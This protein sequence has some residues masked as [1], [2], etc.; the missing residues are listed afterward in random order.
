MKL[1]VPYVGTLQPVDIRLTRLAEFLGVRCELLAIPKGLSDYHEFLSAHALAEPACCIVNPRVIRDCI[2]TDETPANLIRCLLSCFTSLL[3][4]GVQPGS[5]DDSIVSALSRGS[6]GSVQE[7]SQSGGTYEIP[8]D[9]RDVCGFFSGLIL[10]SGDGRNDRVFSLSS[11]GQ[12]RTLISRN[13]ESLMVEIRNQNCNVLLIGSGEVADLT[14]ETGETPVT[15]FFSRLLP[16]AIAVRHIFK[17]ECWLPAEPNASVIIDDPLLRPSY[18]FLKFDHLLALTK[19]Y[20]FH[21]TVAFIPHNFRRTSPRIATMFRENADRLSLCFHGNDHTGGEF[22]STDRVWL[23]TIS[24]IAETRML[25]HYE[26]TGLPCDRVMVFPQGKFS[27]E[28]MLALKL[29]NFDCAVN[30]VPHPEQQPV[31]LTL[32]ELMQ[33]AVL[34]YGFPLFLRRYS[35]LVHNADMCFDLFFGRPIVIVEHHDIFRNPAPLISAVSRI[36]ESFPQIRWSSVGKAVK[37]SLLKLRQGDGTLRVRAYSREVEVS[38]TSDHIQPLSVEWDN[39]GSPVRPAQILSN[40]I[41]SSG[42]E[43]TNPEHVLLSA[44]LSPQTSVTYSLVYQNDGCKTFR[45]VSLRRRT[46]SLM[47]RRLSEVR[48]N[49]LEKNSS[50]LAAAKAMQRSLS[51]VRS[52][53][54][55]RDTRKV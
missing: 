19:Q 2:G 34:R 42:A 25:K 47:R 55:N 43:L 31:K 45:K 17:D 3:V 33:P 36:N 38:N 5:F 15:Q 9:S 18:G 30:T 21:V 12:G 48:D 40:G 39:P 4:H 52:G 35:A 7:A 50:V 53:R 22:A 13:G 1:I 46:L 11:D 20:N 23:N 37:N 24:R 41:L 10:R 6:L 32:G 29:H 28:A 27:V 16:Y 8:P 51:A 14:T 49:Y 54:S 26:M 44:E